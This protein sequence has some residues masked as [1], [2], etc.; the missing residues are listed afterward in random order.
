MTRAELEAL[1][2]QLA[3]MVTEAENQKQEA[4]ANLQAAV[5][6]KDAEIDNLKKVSHHSKSNHETLNQSCFVFA[7]N[8]LCL[9]PKAGLMS[10]LNLCLVITTV[11]LAD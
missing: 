4:N 3:V 11:L 6:G 1:R 9:I 8:D 10:C 5:V 7:E 2:Q